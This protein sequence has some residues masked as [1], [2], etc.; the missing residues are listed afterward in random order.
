MPC[1]RITGI[2]G[3]NSS[4]K[5]SLLQ[6]LLLMKQTREATDRAVTL[7]LNGPL[8]ELGSMK[9]VIHKHAENSCLEVSFD[10]AFPN[11]SFML[12][13]GNFEEI[14]YETRGEIL[15]YSSKISS[16][17]KYFFTSKLSYEF[18]NKIFYNF[19]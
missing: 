18:K 13:N 4:G 3:T 6:V 2:F 8:V 14:G 15:K 12:G 5:T 10:I 16:I 1:G 17:S 19:Q 7:E 11:S 9:D